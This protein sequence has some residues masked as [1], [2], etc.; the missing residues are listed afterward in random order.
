MAPRMNGVA[1]RRRSRGA[2][3][4]LDP[5]EELPGQPGDPAGELQVEQARR[6]LGRAHAGAGDQGIQAD[7]IEAER[8]EHRVGRARA[9][10][11]GG[12]PEP[13]GGRRPGER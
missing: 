9:R 4:A 12:A 3:A 8:G 6:E 13:A 10:R 1:G 7:R 5:L 2:L 11:L